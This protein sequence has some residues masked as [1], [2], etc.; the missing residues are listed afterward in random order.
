M[1]YPKKAVPASL[2]VIARALQCPKQSLFRLL[3]Q[4]VSMLQ[5][6]RNDNRKGDS[7]FFQGSLQSMGKR[8]SPFPIGVYLYRPGPRKRRYLLSY[9]NGDTHLL[10]AEHCVKMGVPIFMVAPPFP[11]FSFFIKKWV[12]PFS[13]F[14]KI[15]FR[16][17]VKFLR[18]SK[19]SKTFY[20]KYFSQIHFP[21]LL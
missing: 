13:P 11:L 19:T 10:S 3:R 16:L 2:F 14:R 4:P 21:Y 9:P 18:S 8:L 6:P 5:L 7:A 17:F 12:S 1:F 15:I 20:V